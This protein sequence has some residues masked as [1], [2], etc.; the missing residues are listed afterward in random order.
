MLLV[1][2][3]L[4]IKGSARYIWNNLIKKRFAKYAKR[5]DIW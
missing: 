2:E 5:F 3:D 1:K 4:K